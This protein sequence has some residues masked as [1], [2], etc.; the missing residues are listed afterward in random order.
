MGTASGEAGSPANL[1]AFSALPSNELEQ[2]LKK[3]QRRTY[4]A[5]EIIFR[6]GDPPAFIYYV[7]GGE[8][9]VSLSSEERRVN[10][11]RVVPGRLLGIQAI[12]DDN[13]HFL[14][15]TATAT[16]TVLAIPKD[17]LMQALR[18]HPDSMFQLA[19]VLAKQVRAAAFLVA[20]MQF[21]D[22]PVRLAKRLL[23]LAKRESER[24]SGDIRITQK[25]LSELA[26]ATRGGVNRAL[27]RLED[28]GIV[29]TGRGRVRIVAPGR[30]EEIAARQNSLD[31]L[32]GLVDLETEDD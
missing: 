16:T 4:R 12:F 9:S 32:P 20:E 30:L 7:V 23:D 21:L 10:V 29:L 24:D 22:L 11:G 13:P 2:L 17:D 27:R 15:A 1:P 25:E 8:V 5:E 31:L 26:G 18:R 14:A 6:E 3:A 19:R 28:L